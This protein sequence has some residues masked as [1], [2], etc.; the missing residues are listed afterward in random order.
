LFNGAQD[1]SGTTTNLSFQD[2]RAFEGRVFFQPWKNT[3]VSALRGFGFG[4]G[5]SFEDSHPATNAATGLTSGYTTDGQQ[6][7]FSYS[8]G[9]NAGGTAWR[10]SPQGY[11][12]YGPFSLLG[13]YVVS[14]QLV[15]KGNKSAELQNTAWEISSG[16]VLTGEES[17]YAGITPLHPFDPRKN[18][19][20]ALQ[21]VTRFAGLNVDRKAFQ[22][23]FASSAK[24]AESATAWAVGLNWFLNKNIRANV[25]FSHTAFGEF[26]GKPAPGVV[27]AQSENVLFTRVQLAF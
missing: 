15:T 2:N 14:D 4:V 8:S 11:Y 24:S 6:K 21:V 1:Y 17:S 19:W 20:G 9:V 23:G 27:P 22:Y 5:G 16:W 13:E 10:I 18:Q 26:T 7:F 12:Y 3:D 25:S